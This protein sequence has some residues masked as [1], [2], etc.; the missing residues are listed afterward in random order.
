[1]VSHIFYGFT[2]YGGC[3]P[4]A[5]QVLII[6]GRGVFSHLMVDVSVRWQCR[7]PHKHAVRSYQIVWEGKIGCSKLTL[8]CRPQTYTHKHKNTK[9]LQQLSYQIIVWEEKI[10][11][12]K[13]TLT[14]RTNTQAHKHTQIQTHKQKHKHAVLSDCVEGEMGAVNKPHPATQTHKHKHTQIQ[15]HKQKHIITNTS[16]SYQIVW[17]KKLDAVN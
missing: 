14:C 4:L 13:L 12:S 1:M 5:M 16:P 11:C 7:C 17:E 8:T 15:T 10:E 9:M 3:V 2:F 6:Y